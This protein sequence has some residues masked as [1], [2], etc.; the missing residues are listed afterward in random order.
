MNAFEVISRVAETSSTL[1]KQ[2]ILRDYASPE[3]KEILRVTYDP[4]LT[5]RIN[6][7]DFPE[8]Y[9][10]VQPDVSA[11]LLALTKILA[12][13]NTTTT[14]AKRMIYDLMTK[15]TEEGAKIVSRVFRKDLKAGISASTINKVYPVLIPE[16]NVQLAHPV[17]QIKPDG[18]VVSNWNKVKFPCCIEEK[19]DGMRI[20]AVCDGESV[21]F[22]SRNGLEYTTLDFMANEIMNLRP[23]TSFVLDGEAIGIKY[24]PK[25]AAAKKAHDNG[26]HWEFAQGL[27]MVR[28]GNQGKGKPYPYAQMK[29][30]VGFIV[31]DV[32]DYTYFVSQGAVGEKKMLS[33]RK[34]ELFSM[35]ERVDFEPRNVIIAENHLASNQQDVRDFTK[36]VIAQGGE[37]SMLKNLDAYYE[38]KRSFSVI[39]VKEFHTADLRII[40]AIEG[41]ADTKYAGMLGAIIVSDGEITSEV[42]SGFTDDQRIELWGQFKRCELSSKICEI[43][44]FE[45]TTANSLRLPTFMRMR[46]DRET[47]SWN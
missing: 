18:T 40:D 16:F 9:N 1:D 47:C 42:G 46:P 24:N 7:M 28:S 27:S 21:K 31:W 25:C 6:A 13:H 43:K 8:V 20:I 15:C 17:E 11:E 37:G 39:K 32:I 3:L 26:D 45:K 30:H 36:H 23:G 5:Y 33:E 38:F 2:R 35:F 29:D 12:Q 34:C 19:Y 41:G 22:F 14:S 4:F 44:Y 10:E